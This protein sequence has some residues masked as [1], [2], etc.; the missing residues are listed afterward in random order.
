MSDIERQWTQAS[1]EQLKH[2]NTLQQRGSKREVDYVYLIRMIYTLLYDIANHAMDFEMV[3]VPKIMVLVSLPKYTNGEKATT[4]IHRYKQYVT[5]HVLYK[6]QVSH[7]T[8]T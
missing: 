7:V 6:I 4:S 3:Y 5:N 1:K 8:I 2:L